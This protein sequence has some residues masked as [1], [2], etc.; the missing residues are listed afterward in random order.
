M[1]GRFLFAFLFDYV[2]QKAIDGDRV[3]CGD[4]QSIL[5]TVRQTRLMQVQVLKFADKA[6]EVLTTA[7]LEHV[8]VSSAGLGVGIAGMR[9]RVQQLGGT[10]EIHSDRH[11]TQVS[12]NLPVGRVS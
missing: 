12:A 8:N 4:V 5:R 7:I 6:R 11:G 3:A 9:E 2:Q 10:L 1:A